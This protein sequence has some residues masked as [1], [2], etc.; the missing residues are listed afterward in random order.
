MKSGGKMRQERIEGSIRHRKEE[1]G[2]RK[3]R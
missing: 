2:N 3:R 1:V